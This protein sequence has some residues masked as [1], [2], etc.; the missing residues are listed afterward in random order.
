MSE[1][2]ADD[3]TR[4]LVYTAEQSEVRYMGEVVGGVQDTS[5]N[6]LDTVNF[7]FTGS[8]KEDTVTARLIK[9]DPRAGAVKQPFDLKI[10]LETSQ[11]LDSA[12][13]QP[14][15][16]LL[17][18]DSVLVSGEW[19]ETGGRFPSFKPL[20]SLQRDGEYQLEIKEAELKS[21]RGDVLGDST[22]IVPFKTWK[23]E[24]LG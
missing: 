8:T 19:E 15:V 6:K 3:K 11:P 23:H 9:H 5:G 20:S 4:L 2:E 21:Y 10:V 7:V 13:L 14:A 24:E 1:L 12:T 17:D 22:I 18:K 16:K